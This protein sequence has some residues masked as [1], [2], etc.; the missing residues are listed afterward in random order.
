MEVKH[1]TSVEMI[2]LYSVCNLSSEEKRSC[3]RSSLAYVDN[4]RMKL[5]RVS[6]DSG[7][8]GKLH[9]TSL[10]PV[11]QCLPHILYGVQ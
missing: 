3:F 4:S 11:E 6:L 2:T 8:D 1:H 10:Y 7:K 5:V 9:N